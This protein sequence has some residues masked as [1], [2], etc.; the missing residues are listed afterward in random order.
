MRRSPSSSLATLASMSPTVATRAAWAMVGGARRP[1]ARPHRPLGRITSSG[2]AGRRRGPRIG[3]RLRRRAS[4][5]AGR[6]PAASRPSPLSLVRITWTPAEPKPEVSK[7]SRA[8]G[9]SRSNGRMRSRIWLML[10]LR[11]GLSTATTDAAGK[12]GAAGQA[13]G[14]AAHIGR[15]ADRRRTPTRFPAGWPARRRAGSRTTRMSARVRPGGPS[16]LTYV[17]VGIA[18][19]LEAF[20]EG[21]EQGQA[22][23]KKRMPPMMHGERS[24]GPGPSRGCGV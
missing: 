3:E 22:E 1:A 4:G 24:G 21:H 20:L 15:R 8:S 10:A 12:S 11:S 2:A 23:R 16:M 13:A 17:P 5:A 18:F 6:A 14:A 9:I 7:V 19:R